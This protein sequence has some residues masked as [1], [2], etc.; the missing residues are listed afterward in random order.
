MSTP[1]KIAPGAVLDFVFP[2]GEYLQEGETIESFTVTRAGGLTQ[3]A[4]RPEP[5]KVEADK[6]IL[7]W[8][9]APTQIGTVCWADCAILTSAGRH[10]KRRLELVVQVIGSS[11]WWR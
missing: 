1:K 8:L 3:P 11:A 7:V 6:S 10:D 9:Q 2:W 5:A 4:D